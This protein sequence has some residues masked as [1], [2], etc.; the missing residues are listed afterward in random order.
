MVGW[1]WI[2][3]HGSSNASSNRPT[4][5]R[6]LFLPAILAGSVWWSCA[7]SFFRIDQLRMDPWHVFCRTWRLLLVVDL[8]GCVCQETSYSQIY[9]KPYMWAAGRLFDIWFWD[10]LSIETPD[11]LGTTFKAPWPEVRAENG[12][13]PP[14]SSKGYPKALLQGRRMCTQVSMNQLSLSIRNIHVCIFYYAYMIVYAYAYLSGWWSKNAH[15]PVRPWL[16]G[17]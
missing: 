4:I 11:V 9:M 15:P 8:S 12:A 3:Q 1:S 5:F 2:G 6:M 14:S 7:I 16:R 10:L 13:V 17:G